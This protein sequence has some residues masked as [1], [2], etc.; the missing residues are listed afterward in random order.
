MGNFKSWAKPIEN[1][2]F[3]KFPEVKSMKEQIWAEFTKTIPFSY[4]YIGLVST[5]QFVGGVP[6]M[7]SNYLEG[8][9]VCENFITNYNKLIK[10]YGGGGG[11]ST[12][13]KDF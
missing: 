13:E 8:M 10:T 7:P 4:G 1:G 2:I 11:G 12:R 3:K 5:E 6:E 9:V